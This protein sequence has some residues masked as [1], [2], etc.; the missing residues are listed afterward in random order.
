MVK[1]FASAL[2]RNTSLEDVNLSFWGHPVTLDQ[3]LL[4]LT[5]AMV[6]NPASRVIRGEAALLLADALSTLSSPQS[7]AVQMRYLE[8]FRLA[9]I[10]E[11]MGIAT[12]SAAANI[13]RV[14]ESLRQQL[15]VEFLENP[16]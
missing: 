12:A 2:G 15:P 7:T 9:E 10:A 11:Y 16:S 4:K 5:E 6:S 8:G 1:K 14:L 3:F 13:R